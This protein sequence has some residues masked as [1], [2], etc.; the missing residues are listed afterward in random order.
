MKWSTK[1]IKKYGKIITKCGTC[2]V[3]FKIYRCKLKKINYCSRAC[4]KGKQ[5]FSKHAPYHWL[6]TRLCTVSRDRGI[7]M[8]L[9]FTQFL[10]FIQTT[11]CHYCCSKIIWSKHAGTGRYRG[12]N[13]D[14]K[15]PKIGYTKSNC[16]VCCSRCNKAK[17][18][19]FTYDEW[20]EVGK[21]LQRLSCQK[22]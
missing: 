6:Y 1:R 20:V 19:W 4:S 11:K 9:S 2:S 12:Y 17:N 16:V 10:T 7:R 14:R 13:L 5:G 3:N 18:I 8:S 21:T 15:N 22:D